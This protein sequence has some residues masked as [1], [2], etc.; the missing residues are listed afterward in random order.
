MPVEISTRV[1]IQNVAVATD[2]AACSERA[3]QHGLAV[4]RH[5]GAAIHFLHL[6]RPSSFPMAAEMMPAL[7]DAADRDYDHLIA[8][9][10]QDHRLDGIEFHRCVEQGEIP[11]LAG[12]FVRDRHI[13]LLIVGTHG[14]TGIQRL[15]LGS[16]AQQI[17]HSVRCPVLTVGPLA[18]GIGPQLQLRRVL[19][20]T[21]LSR[22]SLAAVPYALTAV[23]QWHT[24][25]D[26]L[27]VCKSG[28]P[29]HRGVMERL[30]ADLAH[31]IDAS[32]ATPPHWE[33]LSG[34]ASPTI[35]NFAAVH[36]EDL[37]VLGLKPQRSLYNAS[38]W[39]HAYEIVRQAPCPVLS[40]R[41]AG[42]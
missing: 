28:N 7:A 3:V 12:A 20:A 23:E 6:L 40:I 1:K 9:L 4:A 30:A 13:D 35:L 32:G 15:L 11:S 41:C 19:Y 25:L 14:R 31:D 26:M 8:R 10:L 29:G 2:F 36:H 17:F 22:E 21:D 33:V 18:P 5:F 38:T 27:H 24:Q 39:S 34:K 37:I 16:V 42:A